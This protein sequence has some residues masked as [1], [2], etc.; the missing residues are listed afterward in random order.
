[1]SRQVGRKNVEA[2][3]GEVSRLQDP[4]AVVVEHAV[5]EDD[6]RLGGVEWLAAGVA[7][8]GGSVDLQV[9]IKP[10]PPPSTPASGRRSDRPDLPG[11]S[12][13]EW[14][15]ARCPRFAAPRRSCGSAWCWPGGSP[16]NGSRRRWPG[17]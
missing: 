16:A 5:D 14:S 1:M 17:G 4:D 8:G 3:V 11:R 15:P 12:T 9:H 6:R 2:V 10:S 7:E 13:G